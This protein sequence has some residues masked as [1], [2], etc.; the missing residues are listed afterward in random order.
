MDNFDL[1]KYLAEGRLLK[2]DR[3]AEELTLDFG[4]PKYIKPGSIKYKKYNDDEDSWDLLFTMEIPKEEVMELSNTEEANRYF[5]NEYEQDN[6]RGPG[7]YFS[8]SF[9]NVKDGGDMWVVTVSAKGGLD[10]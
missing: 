10:I 2:E 6:Y 8:K 9:V 1:K 3:E 5:K 4:T 7:Q